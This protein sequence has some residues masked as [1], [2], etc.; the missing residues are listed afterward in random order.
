MKRGGVGACFTICQRS[1]E[2]FD[3]GR[4]VDTRV[5]PSRQISRAAEVPAYVAAGTDVLKLQGRSLPPEMLAPL[6]RRYRRILDGGA[7]G[8]RVTEGSAALP[9]SWTVVG[10]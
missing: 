8:R 9:A 6:V 2:L 1:W 3:A 7:D 5:F 10:R 4:R